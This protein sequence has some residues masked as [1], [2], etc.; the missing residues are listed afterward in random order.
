M[1]NLFIMN[2]DEVKEIKAL[3]KQNVK[4]EKKHKEY[5]TN[6]KLQQKDTTD[7]FTQVC[8]LYNNAIKQNSTVMAQPVSPNQSPNQQPTIDILHSQIKLLQTQLE[9]LTDQIRVKDKQLEMTRALP[10]T[11]VTHVTPPAG[12]PEVTTTTDDS[13]STKI[14]DSMTYKLIEEE[15]IK[16]KNQVEKQQKILQRTTDEKVE[17]QNKYNNQL[18]ICADK[19]VKI[20]ELERQLKE[21]GFEPSEKSLSSFDLLEE[22]DSD[23]YSD[24]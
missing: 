24:E 23:D 1:N 19:S 9:F 16:L 10:Q 6:R 12:P 2:D 17:W 20:D 3:L 13:S 21:L 11:H 4:Y 18:D 14:K 8:I 22:Y 15:N 7:V 5:N